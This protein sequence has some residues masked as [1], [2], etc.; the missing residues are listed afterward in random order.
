MKTMRT[1]M[2]VDHYNQ[3]HL[4]YIDPLLKWR[5]MS[6]EGLRDSFPQRPSYSNFCRV[7]RLLEKWNIIEKYRHPFNCK[8]YVYL[9][10]HGEKQL[11]DLDDSSIVSKETLVHDIKVSEIAKEFLDLGWMYRVELEHQLYSKGN[12]LS[13]HKIIPD[14][15]LEG[16]KNGIKY[17]VALEVELSRKE[18]QRVLEKARQYANSSFYDYVINI[19]SKKNFLMK[20]LGLIAQG[21]TVEDFN[22]FMFFLDETPEA[23]LKLEAMEGQFKGK[24]M[25]LKEVFE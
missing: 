17:R 12:F 22:R 16:E 21:I 2:Q 4:N 5:V 1:R 6:V 20:Y 15:L 8:R 19:F 9:T 7:I 14:A 23:P 10:A 13:S 24:R 3:D 18:N 11:S 25:K